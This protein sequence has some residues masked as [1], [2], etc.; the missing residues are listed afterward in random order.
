MKRDNDLIRQILFEAEAHDSPFFLVTLSHSSDPDDLRR[1]EHA[2]IL[3][4]AGLFERT[5]NEVYRIT[6]DGHDF[7]AS[8]RDDSNWKTVKS[9]AGH[10]T[11]EA[12]KIVASKIV[13]AAVSKLI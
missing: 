12:M 6:N 10:L 7:L 3:C 13:E 4:D 2:R 5:S 9:K 11:L 1:F 8:V